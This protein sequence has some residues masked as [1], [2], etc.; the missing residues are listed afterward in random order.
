MA[1]QDLGSKLDALIRLTALQV[2]GDKTGVEAISELGRAGLDNDLIAEIV[3]TTPATVRAALSR[4][5]RK[6]TGA[7]TKSPQK[8][9]AK[10]A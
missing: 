2:V 7:T 8:R 10:G 4:A 6:G 5:R 1:G 9:T 3:G